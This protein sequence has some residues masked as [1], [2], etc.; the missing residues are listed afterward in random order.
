MGCGYVADGFLIERNKPV[1]NCL[2]NWYVDLRAARMAT[3]RSCRE[4]SFPLSGL[5]RAGGR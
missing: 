4:R 3:A 2:A 5:M 1:N